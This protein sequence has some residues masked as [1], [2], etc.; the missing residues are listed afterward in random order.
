MSEQLDGKWDMSVYPTFFED[1]KDEVIGIWTLVCGWSLTQWLAHKRWAEEVIGSERF[2]VQWLV[3]K[4]RRLIGSK[5][6]CG[7]RD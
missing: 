1:V 4:L 2:K 6:H 7:N 3:H 5:A